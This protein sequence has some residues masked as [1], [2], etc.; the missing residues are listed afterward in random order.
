MRCDL[1]IFGRYVFGSFGCVARATDLW[2]PQ[3]CQYGQDKS[4]LMPVTQRREITWRATLCHSE[5]SCAGRQSPVAGGSLE[6]YLLSLPL[7]NGER[8]QIWNVGHPVSMGELH[9]IG[10]QGNIVT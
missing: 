2:T 4:K 1:L 6:S 5:A 10:S 3:V 8:L 7:A 9:S